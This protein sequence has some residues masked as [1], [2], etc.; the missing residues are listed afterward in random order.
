MN[1]ENN[2]RTTYFDKKVKVYVA[3]DAKARGPT[4]VTGKFQDQTE[5]YIVLKDV[6]FRAVGSGNPH[7]SSIMHISKS[8]LVSIC[9]D[10]GKATSNLPLE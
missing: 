9:L 7:K 5:E 3:P 6:E 1:M 4:Y 10:E 2:L 8:R